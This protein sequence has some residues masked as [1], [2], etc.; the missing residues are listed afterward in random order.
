MSPA[1]R[2]VVGR[3]APL[4][5]ANI[6]TDA[7]I[8]IDYCVNR[9]RPHFDEGLF[10]RWS[11]REDGSRVADFPL[12]Q[13]QYQGAPILVA[14][15]NFG[16]GSSREMAVWALHDAGFRCVIAPSF[17]EIFF[18]N[19]F[20]NGV[21]P[22]VL[23]ATEAEAIARRAAAEALELRIDLAERCIRGIEPDPLP[24]E[25]GDWRQQTLLRGLDPI[26]ATLELED[27]I[28]AYQERGR[29][30]WPWIQR[31]AAR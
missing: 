20:N 4:W 12:N 26:A 25:L 22:L 27:E 15:E 28:R 18:N 14:A 8:P 24:F 19:C 17:G 30:E 1:L 10:R 29:S 3:V 23:P 13:A 5:R 21:L 11:H 31:G 7:I 16:C 9:V 2:E 6:D